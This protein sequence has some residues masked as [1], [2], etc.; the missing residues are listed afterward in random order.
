MNLR[1]AIASISHEIKQPL[2]AIALNGAAARALLESER[3]DLRE[4]QTALSDV[5]SDSHRTGEILDN[6]RQLFGGSGEQKKEPVDVNE[7]ILSALRLLHGELT[8]RGIAVSVELTSGL[9]LI[10]G[11]KV[12]LQEVVIN[13]AQNAID[14]MASVKD[15]RR[16]L[17]VKTGVDGDNEIRMEIQDSGPGIDPQRLDSIFDAFVTTKPEGMGLGL[18]ICRTIIERHGGKISATSGSK[19]GAAFQIVLPL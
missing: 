1:A 5:I 6:L 3:P 9:P 10:M 18:A 13:L 8:S 12:Q 19:R 2:S 16:S 14:A 4:A 11:S 7:L 17:T 15:A